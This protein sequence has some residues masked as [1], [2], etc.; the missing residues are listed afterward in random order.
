MLDIII[1]TLL[2]SFKMLPFLFLAYLMIEYVEHTKS[3]KI[4]ALLA[5]TGRFGFVG[6]SLL[7]IFP[8]CGFSVAAANLYAG[9]VI[10]M[11]TL[12][13][14]FVATSDEAIPVLLTAPESWNMILKLIASKLIIAIL[15]GFFTDFLL[16]VL[17]KRHHSE[18]HT[19][20]HEEMCDHCGCD[21]HGIFYAA[22]RHT[23]SI[24]FFILLV[25]FLLNAAIAFIGE[26][27]LS[28]LFLHHAVLQPVIASLIG[29][30]PNC[31]SS[32]LLTELLLRG[33]ITFGAAVA[34]LCSGAGVGL[35]VLF[36]VNKRKKESFFV[37][38]IVLLTGIFSG[39]LLQLLGI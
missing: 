21:S 2:D 23:F 3:H 12:V 15:A 1:D 36:R 14:V 6:G 37:L 25:S 24:F 17:G 16:R 10:S 28:A 27:R 20:I 18:E 32:V 5:G 29:L 31:A 33:T 7:G 35:L 8:Q 39:W 22:F 30:I 26:E 34:G 4:E 9:H 19:H 38:A 11:G 13:A